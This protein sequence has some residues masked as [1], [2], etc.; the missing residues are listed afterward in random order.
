M[1]LFRGTEIENIPASF[2]FEKHYEKV[3]YFVKS[4]FHTIN[5]NVKVLCEQHFYNSETS[6]N[7]DPKNFLEHLVLRNELSWILLSI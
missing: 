4:V 6:H 7:F 2:N 1:T 3:T 5:T